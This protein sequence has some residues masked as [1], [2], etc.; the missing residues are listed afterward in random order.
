[1]IVRLNMYLKRSFFFLSHSAV[2]DTFI[3]MTDCENKV[4]GDR[5]ERLAAASHASY[6]FR[7]VNGHYGSYSTQLRFLENKKEIRRKKSKKVDKLK[8]LR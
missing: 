5:Y 2:V 6:D 4:M 7:Y 8:K 1:M 3:Q